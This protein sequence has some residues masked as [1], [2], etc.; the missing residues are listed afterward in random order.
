MEY[1]WAIKSNEV[2]IHATMWLNLKNIMLSENQT[3]K[4]TYYVVYYIV[5]LHLYEISKLGKSIETESRLVVARGWEE[6]QWKW[7][8]NGYRISFWGDE[9]YVQLDNG[10]GWTTL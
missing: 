10:G 6:G 3:Q 9:N 7:L 5:W 1:Y 4:F 8:L 2:L